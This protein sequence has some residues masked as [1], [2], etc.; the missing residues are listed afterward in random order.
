LKLTAKARVAVTAM[1]D[2]AAFGHGD[3]VSLRDV[4]ERQ[5][6]SLAFLEQVFAKL[7]RA[8]LVESRRGASGGY[9][10][11]RPPQE[12]SLSEVVAAVDE[13]V[14]TTACQPGTAVGCTGTSARCLTHGL[15][16]ELD[17]HIETFLA[18]RT[19]D[20][21]AGRVKADG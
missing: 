15:W 6:L 8:G 7:K 12:V 13:T 14:R 16:R 1:A 4:A 9:V 10:L 3:P 18:Q 11:T 17:G 21:V 2:I 20:D 5:V 19:L